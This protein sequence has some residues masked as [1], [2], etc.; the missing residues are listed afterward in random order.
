MDTTTRSKETIWKD[1][2]HHLWFPW[3]FES[4]RIANGRLYCLHGFL[5][6]KEHEC[7]L[8]R[9]LDISLTRTLGNR[10]FGT[11]TV[12]LK[13]TDNSDAYIMLKNIKN[14]RKVKDMLSE[15]VEEERNRRGIIGREILTSGDLLEDMYEDLH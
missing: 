3:S 11:G 12:V 14:S 5:N 7:M 13:T 2:K 1:R 6:Q 10:L 8:Y 15:L 4:Y 9:I